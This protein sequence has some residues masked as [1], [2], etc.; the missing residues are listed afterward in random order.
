MLP[1]TRC[2]ADVKQGEEQEDRQQMGPRAEAYGKVREQAK[3]SQQHQGRLES[4]RD[5]GGVR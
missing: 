3:D 4:G 1:R 5:P 2:E